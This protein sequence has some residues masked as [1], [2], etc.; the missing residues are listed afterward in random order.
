MRTSRVV[1]SASAALATALSASGSAQQADIRITPVQGSVYML[2]GPSG[3][4][5]VQAGKDGVLVVDTQ[6]AEVVPRLVAAIRTLSPEPVRWIINTDGDADHA[7]G[8]DSLARLGTTPASLGRPRIVAHTNVVRRLVATPSVSRDAWPNDDYFTPQKDF[9][10]NGEPIVVFHMPAAHTD[11][12]SIV[13]FRRSDVIST[14]DLFTPGRYPVIDVQQGGSVQGFIDG[15]NTILRL[16]VPALYQEGGTYVVPARGR[17][18][19]EADV[20]EYREMVTVVRDR[21]QDLVNKRMTLDQVK[22]A[23]PT[24]DYDAEYGSAS[25][26]AAIDVFVEAVYRSLTDK[27]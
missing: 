23:R 17:L 15:L 6:A 8:N 14:G 10:F 16:T 19:D 5:T 9:Y 20:V 13:F 21:V 22:A 25:G 26:S 1:F 4:T 18:C 27:K 11:G 24:R 2:S 7:G 3:N 12:D